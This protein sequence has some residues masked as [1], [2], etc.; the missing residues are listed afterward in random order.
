MEEIAITYFAS[1]ERALLSELKMQNELFLKNKLLQEVLNAVPDIILILNKDR[2]IVFT[3][4][5]VTSLLEKDNVTEI[6]GMRPGELLNCIHSTELKG[7]CGTSEFCRTCG[8]VNAILSSQKGIA[9]V[10]ECRITQS[11][12]MDALDLKVFA[13]PLMLEGNEFTIFSVLDI[14]HEKRRRMLEKIFLHDIINTAGS[15]QGVAHLLYE[16]EPAEIPEFREMILHLSNSLLEEIIAQREIAAAESND[17]ITEIKSFN[18]LELLKEITHFYSM[19]V[20][21]KN[22]I[23]AIDPLS[24]GSEMNSDRVLLRRVLGNMIKNALEATNAGGAV[25]TG[26]IVK[27]NEVIYWVH[28]DAFIPRESQL[29]IF[30]RSFTTKGAGRGIGTYS[31]KLLTEKYLKGKA[32]LTSSKESGTIFTVAIPKAIVN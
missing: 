4:Y 7:G 24:I 30:Q 9:D 27:G 13:T 22:R 15:L 8:A 25:T 18:S 12:G 31:I 1:P 17:L 5:T 14:S 29:Q 20:R 23:I 32:S 26:C 16:A 2:Q 11:G 28:N 21:G 19:H 6:L 3:N 10:Q